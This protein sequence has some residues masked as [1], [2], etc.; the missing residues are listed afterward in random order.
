MNVALRRRRRRPRTLIG[1]T[2]RAWTQIKLALRFLRLVRRTRRTL[3]VLALAA[4]GGVVLSLVRRMRRRREVT[5][6]PDPLAARR[7]ARGLLGRHA[8]DRLRGGSRDADRARARRRE[9]R[10][11]RPRPGGRRGGTA[12]RRAGAVEPDL[13]G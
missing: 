9:R 1:K 6:P 5:P 12:A 7:L 13:T 10:P 2:I 4:I 8:G 11:Q 3:R